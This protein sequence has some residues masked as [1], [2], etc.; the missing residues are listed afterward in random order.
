MAKYTRNCNNY[1]E[2]SAGRELLLLNSVFLPKNKNY[3]ERVP[4]LNGK[5]CIGVTDLR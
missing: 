1:V 2:N 5:K 3:F 4:T